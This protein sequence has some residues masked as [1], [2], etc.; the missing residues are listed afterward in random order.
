MELGRVLLEA[1]PGLYRIAETQVLPV[2]VEKHLAQRA[3]NAD[4]KWRSH[5][6][7]PAR[8]AP[9]VVLTEARLPW[10]FSGSA[11]INGEQGST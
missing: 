10:G 9:V 2:D 3:R 7:H 6:L 11:S 5:T 4:C 1:G 8:T